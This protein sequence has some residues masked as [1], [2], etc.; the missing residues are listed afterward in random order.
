MKTFILKIELASF[1]HKCYKKV[2]SIKEI[3]NINTC[4]HIKSKSN[5]SSEKKYSR[6]STNNWSS[7]EEDQKK[8]PNIYQLKM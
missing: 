7:I 5:V 1:Q 4:V 2:F 6:T 8:P 3:E